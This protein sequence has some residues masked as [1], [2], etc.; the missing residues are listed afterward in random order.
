VVG[1][2]LVAQQRE[3]ARLARAVGADQADLLA[4]TQR[5]VGSFEQ[6]LGAAPERYL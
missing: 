6:H 4:G 1:V 3:E 2:E 5:E